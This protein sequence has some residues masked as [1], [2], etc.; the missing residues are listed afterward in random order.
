MRKTTALLAAFAIVASLTACSASNTEA[1][2]T[3]A[4]ASGSASKAITA[5]GK[6]DTAPKVKLPT[7]LYTPTSERST[8][9]A[10]HGAAIGSGQPVVI[11]VTIINARNDE[12]LQKTSYSSNGGSLITSGKS[13]FPAVSQGLICAQ[14]GSRIAVIASPKDSHSGTADPTNGIRKNDSFVY[15]M[16]VKQ[17]FLAKANGAL[18]SP[19]AG[20]PAVVTAANGAPGIT[21]PTTPAPKSLQTTVLR[22]G[23]GKPLK[24]GHYA[25]V[26]Y[27]GVSW[28]DA[29]TVFDSTWKAG[30]ASVLQLGAASVSPGLSKALAGQK[31]G[32]QVLVVIPPKLAAA[33]D[34]SGSAPAGQTVVYVV[35]ILGIAA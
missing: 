19:K 35:D 20:E 12:V 11:D 8:L 24:D 1:G 27:T 22:Q 28:T 29:P 4:L 17:A 32:S 5:T 31:V 10:G 13:S 34:G 6:I 23:S 21:L 3:P 30:Q 9:I 15:V 2:C 33:T 26:Q 25:V 7:P 18:Q 16:D 14:V